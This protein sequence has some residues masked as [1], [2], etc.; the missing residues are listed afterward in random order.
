VLNTDVLDD[1]PWSELREAYDA[2]VEAGQK[3]G[4]AAKRIAEL[5]DHVLQFDKL[6]PGPGGVVLEALDRPLIRAAIVLGLRFTRRGQP[7]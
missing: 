3:P 2:A 6:V 5:A 4:Q 1:L 7:G